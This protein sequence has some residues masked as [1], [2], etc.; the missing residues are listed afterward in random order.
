MKT[1]EIDLFHFFSLLAVKMVAINDIVIPS[2]DERKYRGLI[3]ENGM[4]IMLISDEK[5]EKAAAALD[6]HVGKFSLCLLYFTER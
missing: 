1:H 5:T 4:K 2:N 3:L 6:V